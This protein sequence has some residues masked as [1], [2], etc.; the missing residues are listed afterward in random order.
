MKYDMTEA[1]LDDAIGRLSTR[2]AT[3]LFKN[4]PR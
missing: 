1:R 3:T 4:L 2:R